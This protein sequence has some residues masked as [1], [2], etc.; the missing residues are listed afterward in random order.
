M[1]PMREE[2]RLLKRKRQREM[3]IK[4]QKEGLVSLE[5]KLQDIEKELRTIRE[6]RGRA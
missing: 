5:T 4:H 1:D 3:D 6:K 2:K